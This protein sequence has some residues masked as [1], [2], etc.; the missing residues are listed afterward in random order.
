MVL[1]MEEGLQMDWEKWRLERKKK[2]VG[3]REGSEPER[4]EGDDG[5]VWHC[6]LIPT[7]EV[8][9]EEGKKTFVS[10]KK[11]ARGGD[12]TAQLVFPFFFLTLPSCALLGL[13]IWDLF[14][15]WTAP[16]EDFS[17]PGKGE[18]CS[19]SLIHNS[20]LLLKNVWLLCQRSLGRDHIRL[21]RSVPFPLLLLCSEAVFNPAVRTLQ[22]ASTCLIGIEGIC[23]LRNGCVDVGCEVWC[24]EKEIVLGE[25][26]SKLSDEV[27]ALWRKSS[28]FFVSRWPPGRPPLLFSLFS[29]KSSLSF[30][31]LLVLRLP[32]LLS[33]QLVHPQPPSA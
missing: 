21:R 1:K 25:L 12:H 20:L 5:G 2:E 15:S 6:W 14:K 8:E 27:F 3:G 10:R 19:L 30:S 33:Q 24:F 7:L 11:G 22:I 17:L 23:K 29:L 9:E 18:P 16:Q 31:P 13:L 28:A 32:P 26:I 4:A